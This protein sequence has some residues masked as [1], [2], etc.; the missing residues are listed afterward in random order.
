MAEATEATEVTE[1]K[2]AKVIIQSTAEAP[3]IKQPRQ[4]FLERI[5]TRLKGISNAAPFVSP[6][7]PSNQSMFSAKEPQPPGS[8]P[9]S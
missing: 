6:E 3:P 8:G 2:E 1:A 5:L 7:V 9:K 4:S